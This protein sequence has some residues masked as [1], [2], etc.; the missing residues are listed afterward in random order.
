MDLA[1]FQTAIQ[2]RTK[3]AL[4]FDGGHCVWANQTRERPTRPFVELDILSSDDLSE[5]GEFSQADNPSPTDGAE[6]LLSVKHQLELTI[7]F[8]VFSSAVTGSSKAFNLAQTLRNFFDRESTIDALGAIAVVSR[9]AV[10]DISL[11]LETE[12]EGRAV[13]NIRFRVADVDTESATYIETAVVKPT[14]TQ[15]SGPIEHTLTIDL[16]E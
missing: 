4:S 15:T 13:F 2:A 5:Q 6:I 11:V 7:Q 8:R 1:S 12:H 16:G 9:D 3:A 14:V 10:Q